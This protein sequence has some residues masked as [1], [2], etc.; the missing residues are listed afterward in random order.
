[1][2]HQFPPSH[3]M[4]VVLFVVHVIMMLMVLFRQ[5][6]CA[7][8]L[9]DWTCVCIW[10]VLLYE[11]LHSKIVLCCAKLLVVRRRAFVLGRCVRPE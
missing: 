6:L 11:L 9:G 3:F 10:C 2:A 1:M 8:A 5:L 4:H 7:L